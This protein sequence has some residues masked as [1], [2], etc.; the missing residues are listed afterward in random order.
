[1][2]PYSISDL[3]RTIAP[4]AQAHGVKSVSVF[5]SYSRGSASEGSDV[6]PKIEKGQTRC[7]YRWIWSSWR[8]PMEIFW[9]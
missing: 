7:S 6:D 2:V 3:R 5:A 8:P 9:R 4:I 1:M